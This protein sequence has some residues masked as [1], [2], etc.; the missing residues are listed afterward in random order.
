MPGASTMD[1]NNNYFSWISEDNEKQ[2]NWASRYLRKHSIF[3]TS[4]D[5]RI[6]HMGEDKSTFSERLNQSLEHFNQ[7]NIIDKKKFSIKMRAAWRKYKERMS[8]TESG[9]KSYSFKLSKAA[10]TYLDRRMRQL[11]REGV[12]ILNRSE[13]LEILITEDRKLDIELLKKT[14]DSRDRVKKAN[15]AASK[16]R[17]KLMK[18]SEATN[19]LLEHSKRRVSSL[20]KQVENLT[21][22]L[23]EI[24]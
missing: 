18:K 15:A 16:R 21:K 13:A 5:L 17:Q 20:E 22:K 24:V 12:N 2:R 6:G 11:R 8:D 1:K 23:K 19:F 9:K 7:K 4:D 3:V 10:V 14:K